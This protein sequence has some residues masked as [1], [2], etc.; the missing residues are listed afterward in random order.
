[1]KNYSNSGITS[2][3]AFVLVGFFLLLMKQQVSDLIEEELGGEDENKHREWEKDPKENC[4]NR[5]E[6]G[7]ANDD[8]NKSDDER[9]NCVDAVQK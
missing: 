7:A 2:G 5:Y 4:N 1:M 8:T 3:P 6:K 9:C